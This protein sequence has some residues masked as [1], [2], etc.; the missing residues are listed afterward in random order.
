MH[1]YLLL[2]RLGGAMTQMPLAACNVKAKLAQKSL[3]E[4]ILWKQRKFS[5][6]QN[7]WD[8]CGKINS[9]RVASRYA[10]KQVLEPIETFYSSKHWLMVYA[11]FYRKIWRKRLKMEFHNKLPCRQCMSVI[12]VV[13]KGTTF[14]TTW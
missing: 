2:V 5:W 12:P 14:N 1:N 4:T 8:F 11:I 6:L 10:K 7:F 9:Q 3:Y 13:V